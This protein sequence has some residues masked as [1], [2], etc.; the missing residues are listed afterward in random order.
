[1]EV[2]PE[3]FQLRDLKIEF[4]T[5]GPDKGK[6]SGTVRFA[7]GLSES[8]TFRVRPEMAHDYIKLIASD[9]ITSAGKLGD[10]LITSI[11]KTIGND[12]L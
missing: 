12:K 9:L 2:K 5:Y 4:N 1:M 6:Y 11:G 7:N 10:D 8:F 3:E